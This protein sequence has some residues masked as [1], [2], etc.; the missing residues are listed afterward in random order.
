MYT[1]LNSVYANCFY[2]A[3]YAQFD[4]FLFRN[5][6]TPYI[7]F[8]VS[9]FASFPEKSN[10]LSHVVHRRQNKQVPAR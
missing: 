1:E 3:A 8:S 9:S 5:A 6:G 10:E 2:C 4:P 7:I